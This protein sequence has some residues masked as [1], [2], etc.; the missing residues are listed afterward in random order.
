MQ[1][2]T[3]AKMHNLRQVKRHKKRHILHGLKA[4]FG[5]SVTMTE[6]CLFYD[7]LYVHTTGIGFG[8]G[9]FERSYV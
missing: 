4:H 2:H 3:D 1:M 8:K 9:F 5:S 7:F 6:N